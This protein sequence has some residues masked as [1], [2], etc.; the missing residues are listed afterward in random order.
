[1]DKL[2]E[3]KNLKA[4]YHHFNGVNKIVRTTSRKLHKTN[5]S[6]YNSLNTRLLVSLRFSN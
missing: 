3:N 6:K 1:M 5:N 4:K 2:G